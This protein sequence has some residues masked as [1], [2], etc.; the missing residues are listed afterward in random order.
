[1][2]NDAKSVLA[3]DEIDENYNSTYEFE[4][5][6]IVIP[7]DID[8]VID[9]GYTVTITDYESSIAVGDTFVVYNSGYPVALDA[10]SVDTLDNV[11]VI[12]A[13]KNEDAITAADSE[14]SIDIDLENFEANELSTYSI[15]NTETLENEEMTI[16]LYSINY[17]KASK[18]LTASQNI[19]VGGA[20]A[21]TVTVRLKNLK[22]DHK[23][24]LKTLS[25][26]A[27]VTADTTVTTEVS[28]DF[29]SYAGIPSSIILGAIP[30]AG[31][32][33]IS[34]SMEYSLTGGVSMSWDGELKAGIS[35][36]NGDL[37]LIK[38]YTKKSFSFT[39][40]AQVRAGLRLAA[41]VD[42]VFLKGVIYG[43]VGVK[44]SFRLD[45][46]DSGVPKSCVT[47]KG[48][49]Y[50]Q[51]GASAS[52]FGQR[53]PIETQ[54]IFTESNSP[55]RVVYH[56]E[57]GVFVSSCARGLSLKYTT[58]T[59]SGY[60]NPSPSYGQGSYGGVG[61][62][63]P[64]VIWEYKV[65]NDGNATITKYSGNASAVA[66]PS[67]IDG[68]T[69]TKIGSSAFS[70]NTALRS[71]TMPSTVTEI[72]GR[73][74][75]NCRGLSSISLPPNIT[76]LGIRVFEGCSSLTEIFIPKTLEYAY[77]SFA[78]SGVVT[79]E[80]EYD[81]TVIP[82]GMFYG[83]GNLKNVTIPET[84][85]TI[86]NN[87]FFNYTS[88][89]TIKLPQYVTEIDW[90]AFRDCT[91]LKKIS[92]PNSIT[93]MGTSLFSGCTSL[94]KVKLPNTITRLPN[95][96]FTDCTSLTDII[97]PSSVI[98]IDS[99]AFRNC[100]ALSVIAIP[101]GVTTIYSSAFENCTALE[102]I[103]IPSACK[104]IYGSAFKGCTALKSVE[105][106]Y[107]LEGIG[108]QAFYEC[109]AL[110]A[111]SIPDSVTSLGSQAFYGCDSLSDISFGIGLT[112]IP[113][114]A[115]RQCQ[116]LQEVIL[117][118][119][120]TK[121]AANAFAEDTKLTKVTALPGVASIENN[122]F[123]YPAKMTMR[124]VSGSYAQ[125]YANNR[126]MTFEAINIPVTEL[127][128]YKD[129]LDFS[130]TY[131]TK[132]LPLKI[133]PL[134]A[135]VDITYT[136]AD[137]KIATVENGIVKSTGYGTTTIT[138][139]SGSYTDTITINVLRSANSV[140]LD[141]TSLSLEIGDT[142]QLTAIMQPSNATDKLTWTTSNAKVAAVD[143]GTVTAVGAGTAVITVTTTSGKKAACTVEVAGTFNITASAG[144][145]GTISP[146]GDVPVRSN[147][148]TVFN[149][150][151]DYGYVVKDVLVNGARVGAVES[152]TFSNLTDN[153]AITAE[154]AKVDV[155]Y[156]NNIITISSEAALK[157]LKLII[158]AYDEEGQLIDCEIKTVNTNEGEN[159][160]DT[161]V[162][163]DNMKLM[164][165]SGFD[166]M[167]P[168]W[169]GK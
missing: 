113:D 59:S 87:A 115:F 4:D 70:G 168:V 77:Y 31:V 65:E 106:Q 163:A 147:E 10:L 14:G 103:S 97:L 61:T 166:T 84:V 71:V 26:K 23:E 39:A 98:G 139:Q 165:W 142:A 69:V 38:G 50:A 47:I 123:S 40:E 119:Y 48:Y 136:S 20:A 28:F 67:K 74:F 99:D 86:G 30:V 6:V 80:F 143:N 91:S 5:G 149:I 13:H 128:F 54:D 131:Q 18:T 16:E 60:F 167:R 129:E 133:A 22:L 140:S 134:D 75:Q 96:T 105:L 63:E 44:M 117:P 160:Q 72:G 83:A 169:N 90:N 81:M 156:E 141:K 126:N 64:V 107:G 55:V 51:V 122:S 1:M 76:T 93:S 153:A 12:S 79:A 152:Y 161:I 120:C 88:L 138:A 35:Y 146:C 49:M 11:T 137:E 125:E 42:L 62:A 164:L 34:L 130:G 89:E 36:D 85:V 95:N 21:G 145:N 73:A 25:A 9:S 127:N 29:G 155:V 17:D 24:S 15:T 19:S 52:A 58:S 124:G 121:V 151:P 154:F 157:D 109:E 162:E 7:E 102:S 114:S 43:T 57:D 108:S 159:Y 135:S 53:I 94:E 101:E 150:M 46:F 82:N 45:A 112:Q 144:E 148:K 158:A 56:Y 32:G 8:T 2:I 116:A 66:V 92:M 37:R 41:D 100:S 110:A 78:D 3:D 33:A 111:V 68:Y 118:R 104:Q 27:I 132:V